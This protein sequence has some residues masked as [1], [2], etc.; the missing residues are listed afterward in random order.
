MHSNSEKSEFSVIGS[1]GVSNDPIFDSS[2]S[3]NSPSDNRDDVIYADIKLELFVDAADVGLKC[4]GCH[5]TTRNRSVFLNFCLHV[6]GS[7]D[8]SVLGHKPSLVGSLWHGP[9][10][11]LGW[12]GTVFAVHAVLHVRASKVVRILSLV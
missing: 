1:P 5:Y 2:F 7:S 3:V 11:L 6:V 4:I 8:G 12:V 9:A 10:V